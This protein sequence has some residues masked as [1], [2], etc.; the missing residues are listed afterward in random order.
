[1]LFAICGYLNTG[2]KAV[3]GALI[4]VALEA[5][6]IGPSSTSWTIAAISVWIAA[7]LHL[8]FNQ[9]LGCCAI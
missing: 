7:S 8:L 5:I 6:G 3:A 2:D 4:F 1:M 9:N